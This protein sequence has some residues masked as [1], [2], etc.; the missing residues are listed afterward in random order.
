MYKAR[1]YTDTL[2]QICALKKRFVLDIILRT[3]KN[4]K[5]LDLLVKHGA[6]KNTLTAFNENPYDM[7]I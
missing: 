4:T 1:V 6:E 7:A 5:L 2:S 3:L